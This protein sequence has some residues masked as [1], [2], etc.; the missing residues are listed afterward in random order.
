MTV[1]AT[2]ASRNP[3]T[4]EVVGEYPVAGSGEVAAAVER[5]RSDV[6]GCCCGGSAP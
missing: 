3:A 6:S 1:P 2:L 5:A 4:G